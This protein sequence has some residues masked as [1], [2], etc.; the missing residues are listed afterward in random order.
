MPS[1]LN[2]DFA[3]EWKGK[4]DKDFVFLVID[5]NRGKPWLFC[6]NLFY[7]CPVKTYSD[8]SQF[9]TVK[10]LPTSKLAFARALEILTNLAIECEL[11]DKIN[12]AKGNAAP[13][14]FIF[15]KNKSEELQKS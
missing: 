3:K 6:Q 13:H 5:K 7:R 12:K 15:P 11:G 8:E 4:W 14:S 9:T 1:H 2:P 10:T